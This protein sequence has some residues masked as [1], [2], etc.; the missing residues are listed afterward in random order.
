MLLSTSPHH[1]AFHPEE[2]GSS[3]FQHFT[4]RLS[5]K[6]EQLPF[7][8]CLRWVEGIDVDTTLKDRWLKIWKIAFPQP[9]PQEW[10][11]RIG[12]NPPPNWSCINVSIVVE[13]NLRGSKICEK[14]LHD[15][16]SSAVSRLQSKKQESLHCCTWHISL[17]KTTAVLL[18]L[19][20]MPLEVHKNHTIWIHLV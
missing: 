9:F 8:Y 18:H 10:T 12:A 13:P 17:R 2:G 19:P 20:M 5:K 4:S 15:L 7:T 16:K 11:R 3:A 6:P 1:G 14:N